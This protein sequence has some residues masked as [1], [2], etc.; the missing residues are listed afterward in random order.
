MSNPD[1]DINEGSSK[2]GNDSVLNTFDFSHIDELDP[3]IADGHRVIYDREV[4]FEMRNEVDPSHAQD[5][6]NLEAIRAKVLVLGDEHN[7]SNVRLELT[8]EAN[9][10]LHFIHNMTQDSFR[11]MQEQQKL[12]IDFP[13]FP[14]LLIRM[15]NCCIK[16]PQSHLAVC[17]MYPNGRARVDFIQNM[18]Y[19]FVELLSCEFAQSDEETTRRQIHYRYNSQKSRLAMMQ[20]RLQDVNQLVKIKNPSLLLQLQRTPQRIPQN[21]SVLSPTNLNSTYR[22]KSG[23]L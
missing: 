21:S 7:P 19:K 16:E 23:G 5:V 1:L 12:M 13:D 2:I 3:A 15:L 22:S 11:S 8:S 14:N 9:L 18:E 10:F 17:S 20:A 4:P 6:G